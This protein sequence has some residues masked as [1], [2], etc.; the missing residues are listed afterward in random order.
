MPNVDVEINGR[1]YRAACEPGQESRLHELAAYVD[2]RLKALS[3]GGRTG[4]EA[5]TLALTCLVLADELQDVITGR[6]A[7]AG[8]GLVPAEVP[9]QDDAALVAAVDGLSRRI[10]EVAARLERADG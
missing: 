2:G 3:N 6:S 9:R 4:T 7:L 8:R 1:F 5:Q 10:E